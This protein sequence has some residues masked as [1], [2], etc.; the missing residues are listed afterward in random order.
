MGIRANQM[1]VKKYS[2]GFYAARP[3]VLE[4]AQNRCEDCGAENY[5]PH[6]LSGKLVR[7]QV[8]HCDLDIDN[9]SLSNLRLLCAKC[10]FKFGEKQREGNNSGNA[11]AN[12]ANPAIFENYKNVEK[13][14]LQGH[15]ELAQLAGAFPISLRENLRVF[16]AQNKSKLK[17]V[18]LYR[19]LAQLAGGLPESL[20]LD[21]GNAPVNRAE[22]PT[23][24]FVR[25]GETAVIAGGLP[26]SVSKE[27]KKEERERR[28]EVKRKREA[29][30]AKHA[31][32]LDIEYEARREA[33]EADS[34]EP[35]KRKQGRPSNDVHLPYHT[36]FTR[37]QPVVIY[38]S[39]GNPYDAKTG[40]Q[41]TPEEE[42]EAYY[43]KGTK[44]K[45]AA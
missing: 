5:K 11:P 35:R 31:E 34:E 32:K 36:L 37:Q 40:K 25:I 8:H 44:T 1:S 30:R 28:K 43:G 23:A 10:H 29:E 3:L 26:Q 17:K 12:Q 38:K 39:D 41:L 16:I 42:V 4:R 45:K 18:R 20:P 2:K 21:T 14:N 24:G 7:L 27:A 9:N 15:R 13:N 19:E 22:T 6:P 33:A